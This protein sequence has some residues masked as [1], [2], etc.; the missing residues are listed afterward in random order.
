MRE[1]PGGPPDAPPSD[2]SELCGGWETAGAAAQEGFVDA[3]A[4]SEASCPAT[5]GSLEW[6]QEDAFTEAALDP[7]C[8][9]LARE[10]S[11]H[12]AK[13]VH[14][15]YRSCTAALGVL[16]CSQRL[17]DRDNAWYA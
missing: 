9:L 12:A 17:T 1:A 14:R 15:V 5:L 13:W 4:V 3:G 16:E 10:F 8:V 7:R 2:E 6:L 11:S